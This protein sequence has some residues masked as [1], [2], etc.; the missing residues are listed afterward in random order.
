M[1]RSYFPGNSLV[2]R[3]PGSS[4]RPASRIG[5][6]QSVACILALTPEIR[7]RL[8]SSWND[9]DPEPAAASPAGRKEFWGNLTI[10]AEIKRRRAHEGHGSRKNAIATFNQCSE[11]PHE[12]SFSSS[13][14]QAS[15]WHRNRGL[16]HR[17]PRSQR[18]KCAGGDRGHLVSCAGGSL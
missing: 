9:C 3:L 14:S 7:G 18:R 12:T 17:W 5:T 1:A 8:A 10:A 11:T 6:G 4:N 15:R 16:P 2:A 13:D